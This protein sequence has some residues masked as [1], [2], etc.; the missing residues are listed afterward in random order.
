MAVPISSQVITVPILSPAAFC[1]H[2]ISNPHS[3]CDR[4][5]LQ[6]VLI[7]RHEAKA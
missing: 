5:P 7:H 1:G 4:K 2:E 6:T 3:V